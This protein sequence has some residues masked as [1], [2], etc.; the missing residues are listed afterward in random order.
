[1]TNRYPERMDSPVFGVA[2]RHRVTSQP[3]VI[4]RLLS[5]ALSL[6]VALSTWVWWSGLLDPHETSKLAIL[7]AGMAA[8]A[9]LA[10]LW[11]IRDGQ[12]HRPLPV[13]LYV[14]SG[15]ILGATTISAF[16]APAP[17]VAWLGVGGSITG[18]AIAT[19][20][21]VVALMVGAQLRVAGWFPKRSVVYLAT[22]VAIAASA[23]QRMGWIDL[24]PGGPAARLF[25]PLGNELMVGWVAL[26]VLLSALA[27]REKVALDWGMMLLSTGWLVW[28]DQ[29][30]YWLALLVGALVASALRY[31]HR[32][33]HEG[34][35]QGA[36]LLL[37]VGLSIAGLFVPVPTPAELPAMAR[38]GTQASA[39]VTSEAWMRSWAFGTG[40]G[41]WS[42]LYE[43]V[44][45]VEAN[46]GPFFAL[47]Y[48]VGMNWW[49]TVAAQ[50][51][52]VGLVLRGALMLLVLIQSIRLARNDDERT[53][54]AVL[55]FGV[56]VMLLVTHPY[57]WILVVA[58]LLLGRAA[59]QPAAWTARTRKGAGIAGILFGM[60]FLVAL[61]FQ[62]GRLS[63]D[64]G[65]FKALSSPVAADTLRLAQ[66]SVR[67]ASWVPDYA[68]ILSQAYIRQIYEQLID[69]TALS[70]EVQGLLAEA[71]SHAKRT[72]SRWPDRA[73]AWMMQGATYQAISPVTRGADQFAIQAYQEAMRLA[74]Q[75]PEA[76]LAIAEV[77]RQRADSAAPPT[78]TSTPAGLEAYRLEQRRLATQWLQ[79]AYEKKSDDPIIRYAYATNLVQMGEAAAA[80]PLFQQ[81][82]TDE[83]ERLDLGLEYATVLG[84]L[85]RYDEAI[86]YAQRI[87]SGNPLYETSRRLLT[88]W[89]A[90]KQDWVNALSTWKSLP[91]STQA[92]LA[93]RTRLRELQS[94]AG[95][96]G[97]R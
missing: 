83:P 38:L 27:K 22:F 65:L 29:G 24:S 66:T 58:G 92:T 79:R 63:A 37:A 48:D 31:H 14:L 80:L 5:G 54:E 13:S 50:E 74:P 75:R 20:L 19:F 52:V 51:G 72:T 15:L 88:D 93:F 84:M 7:L 33:R 40:Q 57:T 56:A 44:R 85:R 64:R 45:P 35:A 8:S 86:P 2:E 97:R 41:T 23:G 96:A 95:T 61:V 43:R 39:H 9:L 55:A 90:A 16:Q 82:V 6:T 68:A 17:W 26:F 76:P 70:Q 77:Y 34:R 60:V 78:A 32:E 49:Y 73:D 62:V 94:K 1:M 30:E 21:M 69:L 10:G 36:A 11:L 4:M 53:E 47:R 46:R 91:T 71:V 18:S 59:A 81:L 3:S 42:E 25:S 87:G 67:R 89:Y 28:L 12:A